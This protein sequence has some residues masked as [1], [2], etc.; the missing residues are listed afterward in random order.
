V[1]ESGDTGTLDVDVSDDGKGLPAAA[2]SSPPGKGRGLADMRQRAQSLGG[3]LQIDADAS[4]DTRAAPDA[5]RTG[6]ARRCSSLFLTMRL[7]R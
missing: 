6:P 4:S 1:Q 3:D 7:P 2:D 5:R